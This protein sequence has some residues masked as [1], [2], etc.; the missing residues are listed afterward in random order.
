MMEEMQDFDAEVEKCKVIAA[1]V[2]NRLAE[3]H[4]DGNAGQ[5]IL[6]LLITLAALFNYVNYRYARRGHR[7]HEGRSERTQGRHLHVQGGTRCPRRH[8]GARRQHRGR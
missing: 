3:D 8:D 2:V 7:R 5:F 1:G 4:P 6:A